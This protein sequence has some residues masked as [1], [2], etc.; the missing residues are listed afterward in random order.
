MSGSEDPVLHPQGD[1][2][3]ALVIAP[4]VRVNYLTLSRSLHF[5]VYAGDSDFSV[6]LH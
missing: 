1:E 6:G 4:A 2:P 5:V 3:V